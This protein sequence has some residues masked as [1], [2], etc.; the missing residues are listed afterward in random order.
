MRFLIGLLFGVALGFAVT[1]YI[2]QR[3][4]A[5]DETRGF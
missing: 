5:A 4:A 1:A 3:Q 2:S